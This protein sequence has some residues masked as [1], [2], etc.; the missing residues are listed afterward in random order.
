MSFHTHNSPNYLRLAEKAIANLQKIKPEGR[1]IDNL[2]SQTDFWFEKILK[3]NI[4]KTPKQLE[5]AILSAET[6]LR[7]AS[8]P[9]SGTYAHHPIGLAGSRQLSNFPLKEILK[10]QAIEG[11]KGYRTGTSPH[12]LANLSKATHDKITH[13]DPFKF[14]RG[15][16]NFVN[17]KFFSEDSPKWDAGNRINKPFDTDMDFENVIDEYGEKLKQQKNLRNLAVNDPAELYVRRKLKDILGVDNWK[18]NDLKLR[19]GGKKLLDYLDLDFSKLVDDVKKG[20]GLIL[21]AVKG[22]VESIN[23]RNTTSRR[24]N[25]P[26]TQAGYLSGTQYHAMS[27]DQLIANNAKG[28]LVGAVS[29]PKV[30]QL[31]LEGK[32]KEAAKHS[33]GGAVVGSLVQQLI[34]TLPQNLQGYAPLIVRATAPLVAQEIANTYVKHSTG[35]DLK[36]HI[37]KLDEKYKNTIGSSGYMNS[38]FG[39]SGPQTHIA[40]QAADDWLANFLE[41]K[42]GIQGRKSKKEERNKN[43]LEAY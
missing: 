19:A 8:S 5:K 43:K 9:M 13:M 14:G 30:H 26:N 10:I 21:P 28:G 40:A 37:Q 12:G 38:A 15:D 3:E 35:D 4:N 17:Y 2:R 39:G 23:A 31:I 27:P 32:Y 16:K 22:N 20:T 41:N 24:F 33:A 6:Q 34:K 7:D 18:Q 36:T 29:D 42:F 25:Y 1:A 11:T